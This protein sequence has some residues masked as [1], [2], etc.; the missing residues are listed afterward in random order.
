MITL[1]YFRLK[2][3]KW[4]ILFTSDFWEAPNFTTLLHKFFLI[5]DCVKMSDNLLKNRKRCAKKSYKTEKGRT[6]IAV[7]PYFFTDPKTKP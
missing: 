4:G 6:T 1:L 2:L 7:L 3:F 5:E